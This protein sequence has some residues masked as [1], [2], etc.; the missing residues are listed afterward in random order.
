MGS[1]GWF[2][3]EK[4]RCATWL[5]TPLVREAREGEEEGEGEGEGEG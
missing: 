4:E 3:R 5:V 2:K 1:S